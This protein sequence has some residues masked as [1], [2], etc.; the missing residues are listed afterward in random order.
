VGSRLSS[1][2]GNSTAT[3]TS[4]SAQLTADVT[5]TTANT[6]Y[7]GPSLALGAGTWL[8]WAV[9]QL[10][11]GSATPVQGKIWDGTTTYGS[12]ETTQG[13][14]GSEPIGLSLVS[15]PIVLAATTTIKASASSGVNTSFIK[16]Q[17]VHNAAGNTATTLV[18]LKIA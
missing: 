5:M 11:V 6:F 16:A 8:C 14:G 18:A 17:M 7:D 3:L 15:V 4:A 10:Q 13:F 12:N 1:S 9:L 2:A